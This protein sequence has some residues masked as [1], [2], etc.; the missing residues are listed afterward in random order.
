MILGSSK[1]SCGIKSCAIAKR[2]FFG[3]FGKDLI[4]P[5]L[6]TGLWDAKGGSGDP[7]HEGDGGGNEGDHGVDER[8][9]A[10]DGGGPAGE[11][12]ADKK[13]IFCE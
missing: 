4:A 11:S 5:F 7:A 10:G 13:N 9:E 2:V 1:K 8:V 6:L 12:G 3:I